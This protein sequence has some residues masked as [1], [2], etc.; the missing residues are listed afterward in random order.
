MIV[1]RETGWA[2]K[3]ILNLSLKDFSFWHEKLEEI[4]EKEI[5]V[6]DALAEDINP[7]SGL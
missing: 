1:A 4:L 3:E 6:F 7:R 2:L 5:H